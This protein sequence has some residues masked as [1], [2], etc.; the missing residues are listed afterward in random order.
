MA[1]ASATSPENKEIEIIS[2]WVA[3]EARRGGLATALVAALVSWARQQEVARVA[4]DVREDNINAI[5]LYRQCGFVDVGRSP[6][7]APDAPER[8]MLRVLG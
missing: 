6:N 5:D 2:V 1:M 7:S 3:P 4:L 8:R